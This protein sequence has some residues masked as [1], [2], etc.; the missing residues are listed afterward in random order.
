MEIIQTHSRM[1]HIRGIDMIQRSNF[2]FASFA[3]FTITKQHVCHI[4]VDRKGS[5]ITYIYLVL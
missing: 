1:L 4:P 2:K 3:D 5:I